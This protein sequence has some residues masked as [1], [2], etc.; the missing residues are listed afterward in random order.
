MFPAHE[1]FAKANNHRGELMTMVS[2]DESCN[3]PLHGNKLMTHLYILF[4][5][6]GGLVKQP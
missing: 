3:L 2:R 1:W 5:H 4:L 6:D